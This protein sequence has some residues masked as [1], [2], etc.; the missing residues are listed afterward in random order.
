M[1]VQVREG[2]LRLIRQPDHAMQAGALARA[3]EGPGSDGGSLPLRVVLATA[4]HDAA[5]REIDREPRFDPRTGRPH[6]FHD[7]PSAEKL[8]AYAAGLDRT[9]R[10]APYAAL[11]ASLHYASFVEG[12]GAVG[13]D[14]PPGEDR[15]SAF[16]A[17]ERERRRRLEAEGARRPVREDLAWLKFF[18]GLSIRLC[19]TSPGRREEE[20]PAWL[21]PEAPVSPPDPA[22]EMALRWQAGDAAT[23][24]PWPF[25][26]AVDASVPVR[27]LPGVRYG[28]D[29]ALRR[30]WSAAGERI[31]PL[32]L[33]PPG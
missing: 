8:E 18:D 26:G 29:G 24:D 7:H 21:D 32:R 25:A 20:L 30:A 5:W 4:L 12:G 11:L 22:P 6:A 9:E 3:W 10:I 17:A 2:G 23:L 19:L 28:D 27:D 15:A 31:W 16:L 13:A 1:L 14:G 33:R